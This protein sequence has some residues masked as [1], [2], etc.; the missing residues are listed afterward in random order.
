[1]PPAKKAVKKSSAK[2]TVKRSTAT[3]KLMAD[4]QQAR[5][6]V[7]NY[8]EALHTPKARGRK[9]SVESLKAQ[10]Q[11]AETKAASALGLARLDAIVAASELEA[12][13]KRAGN[14][15]GADLKALESAFAKVAKSYSERKGINYGHW[16]KAGVPAEV[17]TKTGIPRTRG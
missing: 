16:R 3:R 14:S 17:L 5:R 1:M 4:S 6:A 9:V 10:L 2:K 15:A 8:L 11:A 13:I 7:S 12:R